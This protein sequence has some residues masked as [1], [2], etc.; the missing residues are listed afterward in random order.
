MAAVGLQ[1]QHESEHQLLMLLKEI[2]QRNNE[3]SQ[4]NNKDE[5]DDID[6]NLANGY[7]L[8][9]VLSAHHVIFALDFICNMRRI[10]YRQQSSVM[11]PNSCNSQFALRVG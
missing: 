9:D 11:T 6:N 7:E 1:H 8:Y 5:K 2:K 3:T 10:L 4:Y